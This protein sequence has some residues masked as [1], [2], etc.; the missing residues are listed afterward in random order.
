MYYAELQAR[1]DNSGLQIDELV[2]GM[3]LQ[4]DLEK[5]NAGE[6]AYYY[7]NFWQCFFGELEMNFA[8]GSRFY[9]NL[10]YLLERR[11][12]STTCIPRNGKCMVPQA[13]I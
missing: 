3:P 8:M 13:W 9:I 4:S 6:H 12:C 2:M 7:P 1:S 11:L 10:L 5:K